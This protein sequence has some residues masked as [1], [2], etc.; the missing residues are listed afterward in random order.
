M[1]GV[2]QGIVM[3]AIR[4]QRDEADIILG[5]PLHLRAMGDPAR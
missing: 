3:Q 1:L 2:D 4:E 5:Q